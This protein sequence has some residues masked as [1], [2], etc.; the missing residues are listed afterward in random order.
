MDAPR[1]VVLCA[2]FIILA[3]L[4]AFHLRTRRH[5]LPLPPG[6]PKLPLVGNLFDVP[7]TFQWKS[8]A[9]WSKQYDSDIIH[10]DLA[11]TP[12][13]VLSS[14]EATDALFE[15]RS[16]LYSDRGDF[17]MVTELMG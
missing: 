13:I 11:G 6:P 17:P 12:V 8:Y 5:R 7:S 3:T 15:K 9:R 2:V 4:Y 10:L 16:S 1:P 14:L